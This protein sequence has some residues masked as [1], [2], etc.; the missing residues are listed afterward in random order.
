MVLEEAH[1]LAA[2]DGC[3]ELRHLSLQLLQHCIEL[4]TRVLT[5]Q[6]TGRRRDQRMERERS[7]A[8][9]QSFPEPPCKYLLPPFAQLGES[10]VKDGVR[11]YPPVLTSFE[12]V[13]GPL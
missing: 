3:L 5:S 6:R 9:R 13:I 1:T 7:A 12:W 2:T 11:P 8:A 10:D 4:V